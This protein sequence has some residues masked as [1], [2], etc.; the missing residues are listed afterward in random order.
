MRGHVERMHALIEQDPRIHLIEKTMPYAELMSL[1][2]SCDVFMSLHRSEGLGLVPLEAM[3]LGK[4]VVA[5]AWS[6]N[7]S[8]MT[9]QNSCLVA[10]DL[11]PVQDDSEFYGPSMLGVQGHWAEPRP[12][13]AACWLRKLASHP[14]YCS[15]LGERAQADAQ[16][17]QA[18]AEQAPFADEIA[19]IWDNRD[20]LM[21]RDR[22]EL[23]ARLAAAVRENQLRR[24]RWPERQLMRLYWPAKEFLDRRLLWRF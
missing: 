5:T 3:L 23:R 22:R 10:H 14:D 1:Y 4:P 6:G 7:L 16:S 2:A 9:H 18:R 13:H 21:S 19:A 20:L 17:Y 15:R 12:E 8:Y 11:V 24:V